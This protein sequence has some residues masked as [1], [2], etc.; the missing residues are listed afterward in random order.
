MNEI[1]DGMVGVALLMLSVGFIFFRKT[2]V[3]ARSTSGELSPEAAMRT[4]RT[5][6]LCGM[7]GAMCALIVLLA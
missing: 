3:A 1:G 7:G 5:L 4:E 2:I 6:L